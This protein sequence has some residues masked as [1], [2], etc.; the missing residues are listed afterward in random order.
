M[1]AYPDEALKAVGLAGWVMSQENVELN[2]S[3]A[4]LATNLRER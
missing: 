2:T 4:A 3:P 1:Y